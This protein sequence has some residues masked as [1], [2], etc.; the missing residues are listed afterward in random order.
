MPTSENLWDSSKYKNEGEW[1][2]LTVV[3][4][5]GLQMR[6][7]SL[8][9]ELLD[10]ATD[11]D[12]QKMIDDPE[13]NYTT[14]ALQE[15]AIRR[16]TKEKV[17]SM[18]FLAYTA[19][20]ASQRSAILTTM[21][22]ELNLAHSEFIRGDRDINSDADWEKFKKTIEGLGLSDLLAIEQTAYERFLGK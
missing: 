8:A 20:E 22:N 3:I 2:T 1:R 5:N 19:E 6:V 10:K 11:A 14:G 12:L 13:G 18:P 4:V 9:N 7:G 15:Q 16:D 17:V 21:K